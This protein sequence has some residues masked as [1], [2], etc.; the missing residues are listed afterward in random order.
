MMRTR[1]HALRLLAGA[2]AT[3]A[4]AY[5]V[6]GVAQ[7]PANPP[8]IVVI[9]VDDMGFSDVGCFGSEIPTPNI[10]ALAAGGLRFTQFY[11]NSRCSPSRA[12]LLTGAYPHQ[13]DVGHL[14]PVVIPGSKGLHGRLG[15]RVV[16]MAEVLRGSG[17]FTAMAGKWHLGMSH[18]V[19]PWQRGFD[20]SLASPVGELY[21]PN[22]PQPNA[23][24]AVI[25]GRVVPA[26]SPELGEGDWY[27]SDLFVD[28]GTK[29][30]GEARAKKKPFFLYLP[31]VAVH[32]PVMAPA[33]D[34]ARFRGKYRAGW[35]AIREKRLEK[36]RKLGLLG[37]EVTLPPRLPNTYN[38]DKLSPEERDRFDGM[39]ATYAADVA[40]MDKA[41]GDLVARL[42][43][44]GEL[45]NTLILFMADNGST[46]ETGPDGRSAGGPL[47]SPTSNI[48]V[49]MNWATLSNTPFRY[50]KHHTHEGGI[51]TPLIAHWP[52]GI[53]AARNGSFV[54]EPG[55][56]IDVMATVVDVTGA[57]YPQAVAGKPIVPMQGRS[58]APAF[59]GQRLTRD[60]PIFFEHEGNRAVR[61]G[62]W[63]LVARFDRPWEL[64]DM[65]VDR[66]EMRNLAA[67]D[68]AR[69]NRMAAQWDAW[70]AASYVD[71]WQERYDERQKRPRQ[72]WGG[73][74]PP[75]TPEA[76]D[77]MAPE[78]RQTLDNEKR[79]GA[80]ARR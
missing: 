75:D 79:A 9:L 63:K 50:F 23:K 21:Y 60:R 39:M 14:E 72:N 41:V 62:R 6:P 8:N 69:V 33:E 57:R 24:T 12:S 46:A 55:H 49:G 31:F 51:S 34:V 78:L 2:A 38:W 48:F 16:T 64:Y 3:A 26:N 67:V 10:D 71:P 19:G 4:L 68:R 25:D 56:L 18:G 15:D 58:M 73:G 32:F 66:S 7:A 47:G 54:R 76:M 5:A 45:D 11:N 17:Y 52:A 20:R 1:R 27:S 61:D 13:A 80:A 28:W 22:Q 53:D 40:R 65:D 74:E 77:S 70:A 36:Q 42:K 43:A 59:H 30:I 29:F 37:D 35:D 44:S